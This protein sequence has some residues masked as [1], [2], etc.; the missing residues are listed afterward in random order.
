MGLDWVKARS[1]CSLAR[2]FQTLAE[3]V[4][5]DVQSVNSLARERVSFHINTQATDKIIVTRDRE[6]G[7]AHDI[8]TIVFQLT[9]F[10][11][12][13]TAKGPT[14]EATGMFSAVP[15]LDENGE[16]LL[17]VSG[18]PFRLWQVSRKA[19]EELFFNF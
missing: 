11:I 14:G 15:N 2:I 17:V 4:D 3:V 5:S 8:R 6:K 16:C 10:S 9:N 13:A 1:N 18:D 19:L 12:T 7:V